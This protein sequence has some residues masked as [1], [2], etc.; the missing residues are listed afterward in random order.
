MTPRDTS[1]SKYLFE[2][3]ERIYY[4]VPDHEAREAEKETKRAPDVSHEVR[5]GVNKLLCLYPG[6]ELINI[7][8][9]VRLW[10]LP[11]SELLRGFQK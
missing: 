9:L 3:F 11:D 8:L 10:N 1:A 2:H 7:P 6:L 4:P 5:E